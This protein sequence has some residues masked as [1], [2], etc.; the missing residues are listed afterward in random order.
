[1]HH[2]KK[3]VLTELILNESIEVIVPFSCI[4]AF[5]LA[6]YG[7]NKHLLSIVREVKNFP[8]FLA[9]VVKMALIDSGSL[10]LAG[11]ALLWFCRINILKEYCKTMKKYWI[12]LVAFGGLDICGVIH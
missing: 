5:S 1:M 11:A 8:V 4:G 6:Y 12:Y 7:P 10:L 2:L 3:E 9:P